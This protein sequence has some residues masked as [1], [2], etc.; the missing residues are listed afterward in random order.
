MV[1]LVWI[2]GE[3]K[4]ADEG[5][6]CGAACISSTQKAVLLGFKHRIGREPFLRFSV[7]IW[8]DKRWMQLVFEDSG[9]AAG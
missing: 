3:E 6:I 7:A 9:E 1:S 8:I 2:D 5:Y 4:V